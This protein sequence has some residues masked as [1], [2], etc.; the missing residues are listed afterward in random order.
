MANVFCTLAMGENYAGHAAFLIADLEAYQVPTVVLTDAPQYFKKF[1]HCNIVEHRPKQFSY[2][3][4]RLALQAALKLGET[5]IFVDADTAIWFGA[6]RR[7]VRQALNHTFAPGLHASKLFPEGF[8]DFPHTEKL[9][10]DWGLQFNR[11][12]I[13]YWEGLFA[14]T[15]HEQMDKFFALWDRFAEEARERNFNG[16]GEGACFGIAAEACSLPRHYTTQMM[17]SRLPYIFWH[18]RL[19]LEKRKL[20]HYKFGFKEILQ[21][22]LNLRQ[23][24]W[25]S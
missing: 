20:Y 22:N 3:D 12:V 23:H 1:A 9:G 11:N 14:L 5:A 18:T 6:D 25:T 8:F 19:A 4:K 24:C 16:A 15:R 10:R 13:M 21:G 2:H 7:V 17:E